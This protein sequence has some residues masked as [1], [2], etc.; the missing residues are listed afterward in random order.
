MI[1]AELIE[2]LKEMPENTDVRLFYKDERNEENNDIE[3][4]IFKNEENTVYLCHLWSAS[5]FLEDEDV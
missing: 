2:K 3:A 1:V 5:L 4:I